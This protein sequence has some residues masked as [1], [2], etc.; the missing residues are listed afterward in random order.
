VE[1]DAVAVELDFVDPALTFWHLLDR[2]RQR[3][4]DEAGVRRLDADCRRLFALKRLR[5]RTEIQ[6]G[7]LRIVPNVVREPSGHVL[8]L[9][10][11]MGAAGQ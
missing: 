8:V 5:H 1:L 2:G 9:L 10:A 6:A 7:R 11:R 4:L 3:Q